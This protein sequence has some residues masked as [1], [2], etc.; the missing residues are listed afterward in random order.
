MRKVSQQPAT[1]CIP[2]SLFG[3]PEGT[4]AVSASRGAVLWTTISVV[5]LL[6]TLGDARPAEADPITFQFSVHVE[7]AFSLRPELLAEIFGTAPEPGSTMRAVFAASI[8]NVPTDRNPD[9]TLGLYEVGGGSWTFST[10]PS[11]VKFN[12]FADVSVLDN[13]ASDAQPND[14]ILFDG[15]A[16][17]RVIGMD[18]FVSFFG[19]TTAL[20]SDTFPTNETLRRLGGEGAFALF[21]LNPDENP[22]PFDVLGMPVSRF[23]RQSRY[24]N[25]PR[26]CCSLRLHLPSRHVGSEFRSVGG[27]P[28][29]TVLLETPTLSPSLPVARNAETPDAKPQ[30]IAASKSAICVLA[31]IVSCAGDAWA[32]PISF[33][34]RFGVENAF[35]TPPELLAD[36]F[37]TAPEPG[38]TIFRSSAP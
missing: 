18:I 19:P 8:P 11:I 33:Q 9:P 25:L 34:F 17:N 4:S 12:G 36:V 7:A 20:N 23:Q 32:D 21:E 38:A 15:Q 24:Q 37:G 3:I 14:R 2:L 10:G 27:P 5:V 29:L 6:F 31:V 22:N 1:L 16:L 28:M 35:S 30:R 13:V 26:S